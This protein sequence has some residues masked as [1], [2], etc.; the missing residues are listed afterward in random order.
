MPR[1]PDPR[2]ARRGGAARYRLSYHARAPFSGCP[3]DFAQGRRSSAFGA[4]RDRRDPADRR[5]TAG[6]RF[7][8]HFLFAAAAAVA[9]PA[10]KADC[11]DLVTPDALVC[12]ALE[13][14][15]NGDNDAAAQ[16]F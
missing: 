4:A 14:Q 15:K 7:L 3:A 1:P 5:R 9:A 6:A 8:I 10:P 2:R 11:P 13:A 12:R 16:G